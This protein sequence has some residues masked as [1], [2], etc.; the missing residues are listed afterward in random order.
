MDHLGYIMDDN[1]HHI[2]VDLGLIAKCS[3][4][5]EFDHETEHVF[6]DLRPKSRSGY[7]PIIDKES[8]EQ[9][10][11]LNRNSQWKLRS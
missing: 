11:T 6:N 1:Y 7:Q 9:W 5:S 3:H 10:K 8:T 4:G 2:K